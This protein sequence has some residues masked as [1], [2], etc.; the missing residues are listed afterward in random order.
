MEDGINSWC[1]KGEQSIFQNR[2][3]FQCHFSRN[4]HLTLQHEFNLRHG[5]YRYY[6]SITGKSHEW[7]AGISYA[8]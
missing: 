1:D 6:P 4:L 8:L 5:N 2:L 7:K 3:Y